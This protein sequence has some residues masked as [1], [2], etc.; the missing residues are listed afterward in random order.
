[1]KWLRDVLLV[2]ICVLGYGGI[3]LVLWMVLLS[4]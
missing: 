4:E 1:M 3:A 2:L